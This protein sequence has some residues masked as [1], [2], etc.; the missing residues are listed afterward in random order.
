MTELHEIYQQSKCEKSLPEPT[1][2]NMSPVQVTMRHL[3]TYEQCL[4]LTS[5]LHLAFTQIGNS[6]KEH[7]ECFL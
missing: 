1:C 5:L 3:I 4:H 6:F 2:L 7:K